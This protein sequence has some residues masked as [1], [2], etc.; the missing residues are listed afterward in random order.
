[1][2][3]LIIEALGYFLAGT[4]LLSLPLAMY[5]MAVIIFM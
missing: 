1:M 3:D 4:T 5:I 2:K